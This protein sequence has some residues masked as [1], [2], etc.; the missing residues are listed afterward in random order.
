LI[1]DAYRLGEAMGRAVWCADRA[2]PYQTVPY[3]GPSWRP[4]GL[5]ARQPHAYLRAGTAEALTLFHPAAGR[6]RPHGVT[7]CPNTVPHPRLKR[8]LAAILAAMPAPP[9]EPATGWRPAWERW[10]EGLTIRPTLPEE[11]PPPRMLPVLDDLAGHKT[12]ERVCWLFDRGLM[13]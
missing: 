1:A 3:P 5:P 13:P 8:E 2:G 4:E 10:Q 12:P 6:V 11:P 9:P 7:A